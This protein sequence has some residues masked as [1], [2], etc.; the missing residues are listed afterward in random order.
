MSGGRDSGGAP[1]VEVRARDRQAFA[2]SV[3]IVP[4]KDPGTGLVA[5]TLVDHTPLL[6]GLVAR[7]R[8]FH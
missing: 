8:N 6:Q 1:R 5:K 4:R 3:K 2:G 7:S